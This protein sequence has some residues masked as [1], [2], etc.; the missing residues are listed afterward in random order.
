MNTKRK[1]HM[2]LRNLRFLI[3]CLVI[4]G[5]SN[6]AF[7]ETWSGSRLI[8]NGYQTPVAPALVTFNGKLYSVV[9]GTDSKIY[10]FS[11]TD[12]TAWGGLYSL[13][14]QTTTHSPAVE[15]FNNKIYCVFKAYSSN[16]IVVTSSSDGSNWS[17]AYYITPQL[18]NCSPAIAAFNGRLFCAIKGWNNNLIYVFSTTDGATWT[19]SYTIP[20]AS[21]PTTSALTV[22]NN[23]LYCVVKGNGNNNIYVISSSDGSSW[24]SPYSIPSQ[25]TPLTPAVTVFNNKLYCIYKANSTNSIVVTTSSNGSTWNAAHYIPNQSTPCT[26]AV[27]VFNNKLFCQYKADFGSDNIYVTDASDAIDVALN[28]TSYG[29]QTNMWCWATSGEMIMTYLGADVNVTQCVQANTRFNRNDCCANFQNCVIGGWP[30]FDEYGF[31]FASTNWGTAL[32]FAQ[33]KTEFDNNRPVGFAWGWTGGGGHYMVARGYI[34]DSATGLQQVYVNDPWPWNADKNAGGAQRII[35]YAE[36]V[37]AAD[38]DTWQN[39]YDI[40]KN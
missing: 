1:R 2:V 4:V 14:G 21:T 8:P 32:T 11:S 3:I 22:F 29:Q 16:N 19:S 7:G 31:N 38:H 27:E 37:A 13:P 26:P 15:V 36:F 18:T 9:K 25:T 20:N 28:V 30:E 33:L 23:K 34:E 5:F 39:D 12:G 6:V 40:I 35:T 10:V 24:S 17:A